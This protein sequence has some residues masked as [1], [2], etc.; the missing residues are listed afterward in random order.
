M[1][2]AANALLGQPTPTSIPERLGLK[3]RL[4]LRPASAH[5]HRAGRWRRTAPCL[6]IAFALL[7]LLSVLP[8]SG[9]ARAHAGYVRSEPGA[10]AIVSAAPAQVDIWFSQD[11][12]RRAGENSIQVTGPDGQPVHAGEAVIDDDDRRHMSVL[13]QPDLPPGEYTIAWRTLSAEDGDDEEGA[14]TFSLD[15]AAQATSTPMSA[16]TP[17]LPPAS[18]STPAPAL[19][20]PTAPGGAS[21]GCGAAL[22]PVAGLVLAAGFGRRGRRRP[23]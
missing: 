6:R 20:S 5:A 4:A 14:F 16:A 1:V 12:F 3:A 10:G 21:A 17:T 2:M 22:A 23:A 15:P 18:T 9:I 7:V 8:L 11:M 19:S 13:L